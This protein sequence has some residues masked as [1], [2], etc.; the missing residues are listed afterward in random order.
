MSSTYN[1]RDLVAEVLVDGDR[2]ATVRR[3]IT[4]DEQ[5]GW[6]HVPQWLA[7]P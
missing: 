6:D 7:T 4:V 3:R 2:W 5:I 1:A